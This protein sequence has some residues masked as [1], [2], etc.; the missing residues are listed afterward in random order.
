[1][2]ILTLLPTD[3]VILDHTVFDVNE[4]K[5]VKKKKQ[6]MMFWLLF[7]VWNLNIFLFLKSAKV[8]IK[9]NDILLTFE[10]S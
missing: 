5:K 9:Y 10:D 3:S 8:L 2:W 1:M 6:S 4:E 7:R